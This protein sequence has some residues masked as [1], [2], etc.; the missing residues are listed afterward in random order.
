MATG[1]VKAW[2]GSKAIGLIHPDMGDDPD[3]GDN[4]YDVQFY[5]SSIINIAGNCTINVGQR[6]SFKP[7]ICD[8]GQKGILAGHV[9]PVEYATH[10]V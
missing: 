7:V 1:I 6:V 8:F 5:G 9:Q 10:S 3:I 4:L 2:D